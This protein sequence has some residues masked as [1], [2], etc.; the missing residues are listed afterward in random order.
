MSPGTMPALC[1]WSQ[2]TG[3]DSPVRA[4]DPTAARRWV[5]RHIGDE[6]TMARLRLIAIAT[7]AEAATV[8]LDDQALAD[9]IAAGI[10]TG[11]LRVCG[12]ATAQKLYG[13]V[14]IKAAAA[15]PTPSA[16]AAPAPRA[17]PVAP[18]P[19]VETTFVAD[20][21]VAAMVA[22]LVQAAHDGVPFC[23]ECAKAAARRKL[24]D[25]DPGLEAEVPDLALADLNVAAQVAVLVKAAQDGVPFCEECAKAAAK[26]KLAKETA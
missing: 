18:P 7:G 5:G 20:L 23:E 24:A 17:A 15:A 2:C 26:R 14:A 9:R 21:D 8:M 16:A 1:A 3:C 6:A 11:V 4:G 25:P 19:P 10:N 12:A 13:L 22:V